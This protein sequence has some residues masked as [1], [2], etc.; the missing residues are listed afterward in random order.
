M[1]DVLNKVGKGEANQP[2]VRTQRPTSNSDHGG[3]G[4][5]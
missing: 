1:E 4:N 5:S 3:T 2:L